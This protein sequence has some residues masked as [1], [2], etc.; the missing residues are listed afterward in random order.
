MVSLRFLALALLP[1]CAF[2]SG[3]G[4]GADAA[5]ADATRIDG[6]AV[7]SGPAGLALTSSLLEDGGSF[8]APQT[9]NGAN[10]SPDLAWSG[11]PEGTASFAVFLVDTS[12]DDY[13]HW[14]IWDISAEATGLPA[15]VANVADPETPAGA[16]QAISYNEVTFGY[17]G[18]CPQPE[19]AHFY[20]FSVLA[21]DIATLPGVDSESSI[22]EVLAA[23]GPHTL[24]EGALMA[25]YAKRR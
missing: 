7:D 8:A 18:P 10:S 2:D 1:A 25:S 16:H 11:A 3:G 23:A 13:G 5:V 14:A 9:C 4:A 17:L 6:G 24:A 19:R 22:A 15:A 21:L 12:Y 20:R